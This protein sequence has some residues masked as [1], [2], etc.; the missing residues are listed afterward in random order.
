MAADRVLLPAWD[1]IAAFVDGRKAHATVN[2]APVQSF[3]YAT[4]LS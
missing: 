1:K 4:P 3:Y 2:A